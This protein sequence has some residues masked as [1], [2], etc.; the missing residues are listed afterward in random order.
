MR[1]IIIGAGRGS[2]LKAMTDNQPKCYATV[3]GRRLLDWTL[4]A[5]AGAGLGD[6]VFVG[7][8]QID[9]IRA[10]YPRFAFH[11]LPPNRWALGAG[12]FLIGFLLFGPDS[13]IAS[14]AAV[15][16]GT[17]RGASTAAGVVNGF[18]SVGAIVGG[19]IP[20]FF[21]ERWGWGGV[22]EMLAAASLLAAL[23]L[24]PRWNAQP[25]AAGNH[26]SEGKS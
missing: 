21:N 3:G 7:G 22:F 25:P 11:H 1:P 20:G 16:F 2:R 5:S 8:Y 12:F 19:T 4:D 17:I 9:L 13:L 6:P 23:L 26:K 14:T 10:D 15:D 24:L 18:G